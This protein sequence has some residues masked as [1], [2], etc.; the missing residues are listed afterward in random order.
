MLD[1]A[2]PMQHCMQEDWRQRGGG[3]ERRGGEGVDDNFDAPSWVRASA[4]A[5]M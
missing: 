4:L 3:G 2:Y 1:V 5:G